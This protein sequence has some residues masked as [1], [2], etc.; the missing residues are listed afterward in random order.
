[1]ATGKT[2]RSRARLA[3]IVLGL[4]ALVTLGATFTNAA[5][6]FTTTISVDDVSDLSVTISGQADSPSQ[7]DHHM[8]IVWGDGTED[9]LPNFTS[10]APWNWGPV[11]HT[12]LADGTYDIV[13]TLIHAT[14]QGNDRGSATAS[15][16]VAAPSTEGPSDVEDDDTAVLGTKT[17]KKPGR[18]AKT[19]PEHIGLTVAGLTFLLAGALLHMFAARRDESVIH[20]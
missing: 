14:P 15:V 11:S 8:V 3:V 20:G 16:T 18:L 7:A 17:V 2:R 19:G 10:D 9:V 12:Y 4:V 1:M 13:A 5:P 6:P